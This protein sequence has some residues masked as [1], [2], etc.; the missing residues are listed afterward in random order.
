MQRDR[1]GQQADEQLRRALREIR[2][3]IVESLQK[4]ETRIAVDTVIA[5]PRLFPLLE[6]FYAEASGTRIR[7]GCE[8]LGGTW[9]ALVDNRVDP[10]TGTV[11]LRA[12][13]DNRDGRV[14]PGLF[15][16]VKV[17]DSARPRRA[18]LVADRA[19]GTDQN[20]RFV[21][22]VDGEGKAQY[23]EVKI[24]RVV[25]GLRVIE[26]GL[27]PTEKV[28]IKGVQ[29]AMPGQQVSAQQGTIAPARAETRMAKAPPAKFRAAAATFAE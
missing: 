18:V 28:V 1:R 17:G 16:R 19:I 9:N 11:R 13:M 29:M 4:Y 5:V 14:A 10:Q 26:S 27:K 12:T 2:T 3:A 24:G 6:D 21:L 7:I 20:R 15:A 8:V 25:D 23:R 22:V